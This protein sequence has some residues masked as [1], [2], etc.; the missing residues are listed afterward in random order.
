MKLVFVSTARLDIAL[1]L[2]VP[3]KL[4]SLRDYDEC[5]LMFSRLSRSAPALGYC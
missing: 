4:Y 5:G 3:I 1:Y 2:G